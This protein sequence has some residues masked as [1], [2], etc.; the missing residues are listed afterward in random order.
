MSRKHHTK[1]NRSPSRY[2]DRLRARGET[3]TTVRM[4]FIDRLG[5]KHD[6][7]DQLTRAEGKRTS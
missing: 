6:T 3:S 5:R 4:P 2:P 7:P 1:H